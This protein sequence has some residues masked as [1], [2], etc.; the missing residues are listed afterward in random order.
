M[1]FVVPSL[2]KIIFGKILVRTIVYKDSKK[3]SL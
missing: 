1:K 2:E 3:K